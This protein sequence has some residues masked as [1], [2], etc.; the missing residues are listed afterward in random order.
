M[1]T[2]KNILL[3][4]DD[5]LSIAFNKYILEEFDPTLTITVCKNGVEAMNYFKS[6]STYP[7]LVL[8]DISMPL[9]D[10][11]EFLDWYVVHAKNTT[12]IVMCSTSSRE[13]EKLRA[14]SYGSNVVGY[15]E[16]PCSKEKIK[17]FIA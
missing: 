17:P 14:R 4:D 5:E 6:T 7:D 12:R 9:M 11:F 8:L 13:E 3:V 15:I 2:V 1:P 16:K 10:G